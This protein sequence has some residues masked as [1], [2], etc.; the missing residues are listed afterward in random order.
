MSKKYKVLT[1]AINIS[2]AIVI[3]CKIFFKVYFGEGANQI[4]TYLLLVLL[5]TSIFT[6]YFKKKV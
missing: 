2:L 4:L 5:A 3:I 1:N 6:G